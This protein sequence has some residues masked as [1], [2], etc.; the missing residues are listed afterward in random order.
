M[1]YDELAKWYDIWFEGYYNLDE[2]ANTISA[3]IGKYQHIPPEEIN[4]LD[5]ACGTGNPY[6][7]LKKR[8]FIVVGSDGSR[9]MLAKAI[10]NAEKEE[11]DSSGIKSYPI[12]WSNLISEFGNDVF[13]VV[14]CTGNAFCHELP[15]DDGIL[16]AL[17]N[18]VGVLKNGGICIVD[19]KK[20]NEK[21]EE[22]NWD[23]STRT[24]IKRKQR[25]YEPRAIF[26]S[27]RIVEFDS[28]LEYEYDDFGQAKR[29][30]IKLMVSISN[31][32]NVINVEK[33]NIPFYPLPE[34]ELSVWMNKVGFKV[35][36]KV[37]SYDGYDNYDVL[38][39]LKQIS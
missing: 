37:E 25:P 21:R 9:E 30:V 14:L 3:L 2:P 17:S 12:L 19:T 35:V 13:D 23:R 7:A 38:V 34:Q 31:G 36:E 20:Y 33:Y 4:V 39:G 22:L 28:G 6:I 10:Q 1:I 8:G 5:C 16:N 15:T 27:S 29:A 32:E 24:W 11:V 18:I 26:E